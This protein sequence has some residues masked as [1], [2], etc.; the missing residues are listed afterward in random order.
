MRDR[1]SRCFLLVAG[2]LE[3]RHV[4]L[5]RR[6]KTKPPHAVFHC[7]KDDGLSG[8]EYVG[9]TWLFDKPDTL[10]AFLDL[11]KGDTVYVEGLPAEAT[12]AVITALERVGATLLV[13]EQAATG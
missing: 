4:E 12:T 3:P 10:V 13:A 8:V 11:R 6:Y 7:G 2:K 5:S 1:K 9:G